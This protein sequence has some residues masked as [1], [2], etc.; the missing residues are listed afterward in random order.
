MKKVLVLGAGYASMSCIRNLDPQ[1]FAQSEVTLISKYPYHYTSIL[2]HEVASGVRNESARFMLADILPQGVKFIQDTI[3]EITAD[4][5]VG[6]NK[7]YEYDLL[8]VGLGFQSDNFG[9]PGITEN[10]T[11]LVNF[12]GALALKE[13]IFSQ[14]QKYKQT[15]DKK[16]LQF[17]I[18]GGGF[19]GIE[20]IASLA[21]ALKEECHRQDIDSSLLKFT[22][23]EAMPN[24]LPMFSEN[25]VNAG[26]AHL[27]N[28]GINLATG[29]KILECKPDGVVVQKGETQEIIEAGLIIWTA[30]VKGN[31]VIENSPFFTSMR[32]K[33]EVDHF[34]QP[35]NQAPEHAQRMKSIYIAGDCSAFK[36]PQSGRFFP[37][38]AQIAHKQGKYLAKALSARILEHS[39]TEEFEYQPRGT[40]CSLG[41]DYAIGS[42]QLPMLAEVT[43][44]IAIWLKRFSETGWRYHLMGIKGIF[45]SD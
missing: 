40:I 32:S 15:N 8:V 24:I 25:L 7:H 9:I 11:P 31:A 30:G 39:F 17:A 2:L 26:V 34:L 44:K 27:R 16:A 45:K 36:D 10:A 43:G 6:Q 18:C 35:I 28:L 20:F 14:L 29:C 4:N 38:T 19:S 21:N 23:I 12:E 1:V 33:V 41:E 3:T 5:V 22:C 42:T 37:P 13:K